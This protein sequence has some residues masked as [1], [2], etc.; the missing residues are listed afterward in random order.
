MRRLE[1]EELLRLII[2][3]LVGPDNPV[4][5]T[6]VVEATIKR[7]LVNESMAKPT[8]DGMA[9]NEWFQSLEFGQFVKFVH[10]A[11]EWENLL[12]FFYPYFWGSQEAASDKLLFE[13]PDPEHERFL[14][15]GYARVVITVRPGFEKAFTN[16]VETGSLTPNFV[17]TYVPI[18]EEIANFAK[19][20][21]A[22]IPP[23]NPELQ[24]RPLLYPEQRA[25]WESMQVVM[26]ALETFKAAK[27]FPPTLAGLPG[28]VQQDAWGNDFVYHQP[29]LGADY[30]LISL[31][32]N[33]TPGGTGLDADICSAAGA[34]LV[35]TWSDYTP[36]SALDIEV[37]TKPEDIA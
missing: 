10:E 6:P 1:R 7:I 11:I 12:Y 26:A 25:T 22:G 18:A 30:D 23:A 24:A 31:G 8:F 29:G 33:N 35:A 2:Q 28:P 17:S 27:V 32:A 5:S 9:H 37:D 34:S 4:L 16:F 3:W 13:H 20:N 19:T 21:Y 36:T 14:R 15:A